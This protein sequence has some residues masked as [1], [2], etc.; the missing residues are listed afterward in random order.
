MSPRIKATKS[1]AG[2]PF[3]S[4]SR[5]KVAT[6]DAY[7]YDLGALE[8][9]GLCSLGRLPYSIRI[10]LESVLRHA[11]RGLVSEQDVVSLAG[12]LPD[13]L[14]QGEIPF[15]PVRV[16]MQD[17]TG[18][19]AMVD[20]ASM[21]SAMKRFGGDA[22]RINPLIQ[23]QLVIDHSVQV[24]VAGSSAALLFNENREFERNRERYSFLKWG[25]Q[26]FDNFMVVPPSTGIVHQVNLEYLAQVVCLSDNSAHGANGSALV[27]PD[28]V[29]GMD[30]HT[31]MVNG[32]GVLGWGVGGI[33]AEAAILGQPY[34]M[35]P[36][37][38]VGVKL[39]GELQAGVLATDLVLRVTEL[40]RELGV[41]GKLVEFMGS[42]LAHLSL[43]DRATLANMAPEYG[44]TTGF[45]PVDERTLTY[46]R[47][48]GRS[49]SQVNLVERYCKQQQLFASVEQEPRYSVL[50]SL[51]MSTVEPCLA[52]PKRPQDRVLLRNM[53]DKFRH[54]L[55]APIGKRGFGLKEAELKKQSEAQLKGKSCTLKH[56][57]VM[58]AAI[59]SCTN[60]SNP[61]VLFTAALLAKKACAY[62]LRVPTYVKTSLAP[63]SRVV[64][65]YL[66]KAGLTADLEAL[67]FYTVGYGC[68]TCIGNSGPLEDSLVA[69]ID[70]QQ[71][72][73]AAVLS[74]NRNFEGR[75]NPHT[76]ANYLASPPLVV[77]YALAGT[78][79]INLT[80]EAIG[81]GENG[82]PV[83]LRDIWPTT[84]EVQAMEQKYVTP[85]N[86][87][88]RYATVED[89]NARWNKE[90]V[91]GSQL[92]DWDPQSTYIQESP[93]FEDF[94]HKLPPLPDLNGLRVL[95]LLGDSITTD[96]ISPAGTIHPDSQAGSYLRS[97]NV[98]PTDFNS[99]GSRRGNDRV[100]VRGTLG[101][102]R[103]KNLLVSPI[104]G[105]VTCHFPSNE[106][107]SIYE[108]TELYRQE[109]RGL[110]VI[111]GKEYGS[112]SSRDWAA[113]GVRLL[114][115]R[116]VL[117]ESIERIHRSNLVGMCVLPLE[118]MA[119]E[120][121]EIL[122][123]TGEEVYH[124]EGNLGLPSQVIKVRAQRANGEE[125]I[126]K[127][128]SRLDNQVEVGYY[129]NGGVLQTVMRKMLADKVV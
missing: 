43:P 61:T 27:F 25:Q 75:V 32:L 117:V 110:L 16:L 19:P 35:Q 53:K 76:Q 40:L 24:D 63:G 42:G 105:S 17:F 85:A 95:A 8:R 83:F 87:I 111:G 9:E 59:T 79:D 129:Q 54:D 65:D 6:D 115:V 125:I 66:A 126:F 55:T 90:Q 104:E 93:F 22:T 71:L 96:H 81:Y 36:S 14:P 38:V 28:T 119:G 70:A 98:S 116:V 10:L 18:V 47:M 7:Y 12:W 26:A 120:N 62:G 72:V 128:K 21:R 73:T 46:L 20:L 60:T 92:Y 103:L 37:E 77:A 33:E 31:T 23:A 34:Y 2:D 101:N 124:F 74:G 84:Q 45:F 99:F 1:G 78:V 39:E 121:A 49:E 123:L 69:A 3:G 107:M 106:Q 109:G 97:L 88:Q 57:S 15:M 82:K 89:G 52:G 94:S 56:G 41:V 4:L 51:D 48:T 86:F 64:T 100:M 102:I 113:K 122:K 11:G 112:G 13:K 67:G 44:A 50:L 127:A 108:A 80:F 68:T 91:S 5:L 118:F 29:L 30:S 58:I 114:G